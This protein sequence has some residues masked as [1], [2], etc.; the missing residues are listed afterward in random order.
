[1]GELTAKPGEKKSGQLVVA[2]RAFSSVSVPITVI[3]G[4]TPGPRLAV[5]AGE[6]GCEYCGIAAAVRLCRELKPEQ[7]TGSLIAV[8]V[9]NII[10]FESRSLFVTPIDMVSL[11]SGCLGLAFNLLL[12]RRRLNY[13]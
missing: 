1:M 11:H 3:N 12:G 8:P 7:V 5:L 6:H 2:R 13:V 9:V 10:S 4:H